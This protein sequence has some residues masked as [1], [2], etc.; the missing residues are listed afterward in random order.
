MQPTQKISDNDRISVEKSRFLK[1]LLV[2]VWNTVFGYVLYALITW[3][4]DTHYHIP[5]SY[6]YSFVISNIIS[7]TQA[8]VA[9]KY[10]VFKTRGNFWKEYRKGMI[11]YGTTAFF[12]FISLPFAVRLC[13]IFLPDMF[14]WLDKYIGGLL[15]NGIAAIASFFGH[16]KITFRH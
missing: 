1:Y 12:S 16:N 14:K 10:L 7:V 15:V 8:F 6:M 3:I 2:G 4:L 13:S 11:V 9:H 5:F